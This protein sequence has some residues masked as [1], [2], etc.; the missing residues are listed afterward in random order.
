MSR[1]LVTGSTGFL[2]RHLVAALRAKGHDVV[3][4]VRK[5]T[6]IPAGVAP[7]SGDVFDRASVERAATGCEGVFHCAGKVSRRPEDA[8]DLYKVHV[9]GTKNVLDACIAKNVKRAVVASTSG[10][11]AVSDDP[12]RVSTEDDETPIG[13]INR[14]PYYRS[15]LFAEKAALERHGAA[16][17]DGGSFEVVSVNPTLLLGPGDVNGSSTDDVRRFLER[18]IPAI[19]PGG[20]SYVDARDA[21]EGMRLAMERGV[22]GRRYLL[23]ACNLTLREFFSRLERVSGVRG[24]IVPMPRLPHAAELARS[25]AQMLE[26]L[27]SR[28]GVPMPVDPLSL[29]MAHF[30]WYLDATLAETELGWAPRDPVETLA[31]TIK[32]LEDRG[33]V[34]PAGEGSLLTPLIRRAMSSSEDRA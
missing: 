4:L 1:Y 17:P 27:T 32:D 10:T 7:V 34:W 18:K 25:G 29:D 16:L 6:D 14:W 31:D 5:A 19:P 33:V 26:R 28:L 13:I 23:G 8:E 20:L 12:D 2:G 11:I 9:E 21:A 22:S 3:A 15:K 30:Y 24:P